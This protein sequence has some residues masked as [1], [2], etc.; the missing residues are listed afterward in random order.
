MICW[1]K[2]KDFSIVQSDDNNDT[3]LKELDLAAIETPIKEN[4]TNDENNDEMFLPV[5]NF[6]SIINM[7]V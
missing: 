6:F 2:K 4:K 5:I 3:T 1:I 7:F